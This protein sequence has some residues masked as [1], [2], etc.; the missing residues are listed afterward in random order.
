M[1]DFSK[2]NLLIT[3]KCKNYDINSY[4]SFGAK[5]KENQLIF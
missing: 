2:Q 3:K 5:D 1:C 4:S